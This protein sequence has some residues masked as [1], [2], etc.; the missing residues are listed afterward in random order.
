VNKSFNVLPGVFSDCVGEGAVVEVVVGSFMAAE[1]ADKAVLSSRQ[2][3][4]M[5]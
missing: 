5:R 1:P 2:R 4:S 3:R